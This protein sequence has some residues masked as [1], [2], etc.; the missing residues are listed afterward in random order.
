VD[1][2]V[3]IDDEMGV[4]TFASG[5]HKVGPIL[6]VEIS[7]ESDEMLLCYV[8]DNNF[9][10]EKASSM[11][12]G[13]ATFHLGW[14][15]HSAGPNRSAKMRR[16]MTIIYFADGAVVAKPESKHQQAD[17]DAWKA[18]RGVGRFND[19]PSNELVSSPFCFVRFRGLVLFVDGKASEVAAEENHEATKSA[20][21]AHG[22]SS[23][24]SSFLF[25]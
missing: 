10:I 23:F 6:S 22:S 3:D 16:V 20:S 2:L 5:S 25:V 12:S 9:P 19:E 13:D 1:P 4:I 21:N 17:L 11:K 15:I 24:V 18:A 14:T 7:D 8:S